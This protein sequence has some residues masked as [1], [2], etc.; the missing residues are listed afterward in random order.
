MAGWTK[1][2]LVSQLGYNAKLIYLDDLVNIW[3]IIE[4]TAMI[5]NGYLV[6]P[7][8][9]LE[10]VNS[11]IQENNLEKKFT[12]KWYFYKNNLPSYRGVTSTSG[13]EE[14]KEAQQKA[15][16]K[17]IANNKMRKEQIEE[18]LKLLEQLKN[19]FTGEWLDSQWIEEHIG[20]YSVPFS[21]YYWSL[22]GRD[23]FKVVDWKGTVKIKSDIYQ[24]I[25]QDETFQSY[26]GCYFLNQSFKNKKNYATY[27]EGPFTY[28]TA[29]ENGWGVYG[30]YYVEDGC[31]PELIYIG[32]TS[33][34]FDIRWKEHINIFTGKMPAPVGMIL[35]QQNLDVNKLKFEKL[36]N[37]NDLNCGDEILTVRDV[38]AMELALINL[39][40]PKYNLAGLTKPYIFKEGGS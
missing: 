18:D 34:G 8:E 10:Q 13:L 12:K 36:I 21:E 1:E 19:E 38:E 31:E 20:K 6:I 33:R 35:Y 16:A 5:S 24:Q 7:D 17:R 27:I 30:I 9:K 3:N 23:N 26:K 28:S 25:Q 39:Y 14:I 4:S 32:M 40:K 15:E 22:I 37:I 2:N 11:F 29:N